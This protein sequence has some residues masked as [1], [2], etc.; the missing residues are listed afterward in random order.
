LD[1]ERQLI[2]SFDS[3]FC[4]V[5]VQIFHRVADRVCNA[6]VSDESARSDSLSQSII[7]DRQYSRRGLF[8]EQCLIVFNFVIFHNFYLVISFSFGAIF[9]KRLFRREIR[10][11]QDINPLTY[12]DARPV[13]K[14]GKIESV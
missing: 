14:L 6:N 1:K 9:N 12:D 5:G 10:V 7:R 8:I 13:R 2:Y 3:A 11:N 4:Y